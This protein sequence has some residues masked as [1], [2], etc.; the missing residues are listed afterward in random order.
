[1]WGG[2]GG[3]WEGWGGLGCAHGE[4]RERDWRGMERDLR[5]GEGRER[6]AGDMVSHGREGE[7]T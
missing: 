3:T 6:A 5:G 2:G 7:V 1:V 4:G